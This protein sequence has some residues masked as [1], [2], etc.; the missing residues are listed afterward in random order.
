M[1]PAESDHSS[2]SSRILSLYYSLSSFEE[3]EESDSALEHSGLDRES[4]VIELYL[5]EPEDS[6]L[7][8]P[9]DSEPPM[10]L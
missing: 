2:N 4:T 6:S 7:S 9:A 3:S 10:M 8:S 5:Y 1:K